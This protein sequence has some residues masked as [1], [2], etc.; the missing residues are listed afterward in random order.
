MLKKGGNVSS[1]HNSLLLNLAATPLQGLTFLSFP[2]CFSLCSRLSPVPPVSASVP[3]CTGS[4]P[5][6]LCPWATPGP[7]LAEWRL[8]CQEQGLDSSWQ[9]YQ[10]LLCH[11]FVS[12]TWLWGCSCYPSHT[13]GHTGAS[14]Q[15]ST[16]AQILQGNK[17]QFPLPSSPLYISGRILNCSWLIMSYS[18]YLPIPSFKNTL[19]K[20]VGWDF[21]H[22][23]AQVL[24]PGR[25]QGQGET[26]NTTALLASR[27]S[28]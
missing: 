18:N 12:W 24:L 22:L 27:T 2:Q 8:G 15:S 9:S 21:L 10:S 20:G 7:S 1:T 11:V 25:T 17:Q 16:T 26:F 14:Q 3:V 6:W 23:L 4:Q 13:P 19:L 28:S 5:H